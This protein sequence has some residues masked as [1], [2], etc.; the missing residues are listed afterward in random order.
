MIGIQPRLKFG[1]SD[2]GRAVT[3]EELEIAEYSEGYKYEIIDG[4]LYVSPVPN[5]PEA[6]LDDWLYAKL[7]D[8][9]RTHSNIVNYVNDKAR[10]YIPN[11]NDLTIPEPDIAVYRDFPTGKLI[12]DL[13]WGDISPVIVAEVLVDSDPEK[14]LVRNV[15]LYYQVPSIAEYWILD[16]RENCDEPLLIARRRYGSRWLIHEI[17]YGEIYRTP[18]LPGFELLI[19]PRK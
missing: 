8:Y 6:F 9:V 13:N 16:G 19:D 5:L 17:P 10:V 14:D 2:H 4:G 1:P 18:T 11:R 12:R 3:E 15:D 7:Y